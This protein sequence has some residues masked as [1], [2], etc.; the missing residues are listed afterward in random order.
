M[1]VVRNVRVWLGR[2]LV[3]VLAV[4]LVGGTVWWAGEAAGEQAAREAAARL[5]SRSEGNSDM[6]RRKLQ[7]MR[8][9]ALFLSK[10]PPVEGL[11][12]ARRGGA[13]LMRKSRPPRRCGSRGWCAFSARLRRTGRTSSRYA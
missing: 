12:R 7:E 13:V 10:V 6:L 9:D 11:V 3:V 1:Q 8:H 2:G 4:A 5:A